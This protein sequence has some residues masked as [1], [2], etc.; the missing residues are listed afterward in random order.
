MPHSLRVIVQ[1]G[2][3]FERSSPG[4]S[5]AVSAVCQERQRPMS[6]TNR[7]IEAYLQQGK[8][9]HGAGRLAEAGQI[10][11]HVL[12]VAPA[13]PEALDMMGALLLQMGQPLQA[14]SW[15]EQAIGT[16]TSVAAFHVHHA[17]ALLAL[18]RAADAVAASRAALRLR[19]GD[20]EAHQVLGH[21][22]ART[23]AHG[24]ALKAYPDPPRVK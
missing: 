4:S 13:H 16:G 10:Y 20:A 23:G 14:L 9:L 8:R 3:H 22:P 15:I 11:Q 21:A 18:G 6:H 24:G 1:P 7:Q 5:L 2:S 19:R 17:H 12:S